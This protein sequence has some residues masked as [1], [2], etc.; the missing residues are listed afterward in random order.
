MPPTS[1]GRRAHRL[2]PAQAPPAAPH[3]PP[4]RLGPRARTALPLLAVVA[5]VLAVH[6]AFAL[7]LG[8]PVRAWPFVLA[9]L[10]AALAW[11]PARTAGLSRAGAALAVVAP[12]VTP[13]AVATL[14]A[15]GAGALALLGALAVSAAAVAVHRRRSA[16]QREARSE[17]PPEPPSSRR[18]ARARHRPTGRGDAV[19]PWAA[20]AC[21]IAVLAVSPLAAAAVR[22]GGAPGWG[23]GVAPRGWSALGTWASLDPVL[24]VLAVVAAGV[25]AVLPGLR[26]AGA[27]LALAAL[28]VGVLGLPVAAAAPVAPL[29][30][31][32]LG[33]ALDA[34]RHRAR[35]GAAQTRPRAA[36]PPAWRSHGALA[37]VAAAVALA[38]VAPVWASSLRRLPPSGSPATS[39]ADWVSEE[40][41]GDARVA[42]DPDLYARLA[43][44]G[45]PERE[46]VALAAEGA[47]GEGD[48]AS[49]QWLVSTGAVRAMATPGSWAREALDSSQPVRVFGTGEDRVEVRRL[50]AAPPPAPDPEPAEGEPAPTATPPAPAPSATEP[51]S[52][53][54]PPPSA[55]SAAPPAAVRALAANPSVALGEDARA[56]LDATQV[57]ARLV[58]LLVHLASERDLSVTDL[59]A[60][61]GA[62][63][64]EPRRTA[65]LDQ[66]DGAP[67]AE[68]SAAV[69]ELRAE[70][71]SQTD[72]YRATVE[73]QEGGAL[74]L[75]VLELPEAP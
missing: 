59:P 63:E 29:V 10:A 71:A 3:R 32:V 4:V 50:T 55:A 1:P 68:R 27:A 38:A 17:A 16:P 52:P 23:T 25:A 67:V 33:R 73:V 61:R 36:T 12:L 69:E 70:L 46:L 37:G 35:A 21:L 41:L 51:S 31:L 49:A 56:V 2:A 45:T 19:L 40:L 48:A 65:V 13:T 43:A 44:E 5:L 72:A 60:A 47:G 22:A 74:V 18:A 58:A 9:P 6:G 66:I 15:P 7:A 42:V 34:A 75:L 53:V 26:A 24:A 8:G 64:D 54:A 14:A 20:A 30:G 57:D 11:V 62:R 39:A 28:A